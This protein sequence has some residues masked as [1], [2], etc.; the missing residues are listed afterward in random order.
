MRISCGN[1]V[2]QCKMW[3]MK[4]A[5]FDDLK[6][7]YLL[8]TLIQQNNLNKT[9]QIHKVTPSAISQS[10]KS[11]EVSLGYP[12]ITKNIEGWKLTEKGAEVLSKAENI[13]TAMSDSFAAE[14]TDELIIN[15]LSIGAYE[16]FAA[17]AFRVMGQKLREDFPAIKLNFLVA[18][19]GDLVRKIISGEICTALMVENDS[20][21]DNIITKELY[22]DT[23]GLFASRDI[24]FGELKEN[25]KL[26]FAQLT[27]GSEGHPL[28]F[29]RFLKNL[30]FIKQPLICDSYEILRELAESGEVVAVLPTRVARKSR[31]PLFQVGQEAYQTEGLHR[32]L[33]AASKT[34]DPRELSYLHNILIEAQFGS[35]LTEQ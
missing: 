15:S 25:A 7:L 21:N 19:S 5:R 1:E 28:Y 10:I 23:L 2:G 14:E 13:F 11:L 22:S 30:S 31:R 3:L 35:S 16:S 24:S 6:K 33:I 26:V 9:A 17:D 8:K 32:I 18:R 29:K 20:I 4:T 12:V 27:P 34:C